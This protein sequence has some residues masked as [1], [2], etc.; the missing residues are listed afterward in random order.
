MSYFRSYFEKN[1]TLIKNSQTNTAKNPTTEIFYG[2]GF[3][4][5]IFKVDL[6]D[7][8]TKVDSGEL[9]I[10]SN[11][12]H[13]L[14]MT[15][16]IFGDEGLRG[17]NRTT[18]R[19]RTSSFD[20]IVFK[21]TQYWD[22]G[23]GF[24]YIDESYDFVSGNKTYDERPSNWFYRTSMNTWT[25]NGV[26]DTN[27]IIVNT[28]HFDNGNENLEVDITDYVNGIIQSGYT[29]QGLGIAFSIVYQDLQTPTD[30]SVAFFT[31]YTQT[32]FEPFVESYFED[33]VVDNRSDFSTQIDQNL[34]L[35]VTE[36]G[37]YVN[38]DQLPIVDVLDNKNILIN[39]L[40]DLQTQL[41]KKGIYKVTF[42]LNDTTCA[43]GK[44]F[45]IDKWKNIKIHGITLDDINQKFIPK[46]LT[47]SIKIGLNS[48]DNEKYAVQFYGVKMSEK[49]K[50][51]DIRKIS[52]NEFIALK[53][54]CGLIFAGFPCQ[55][56]SNAGKK[57]L[58]DPRNELVYE[59]ND[60]CLRVNT[61]VQNYPFHYHIKKFSN[62]IEKTYG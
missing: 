55:G 57:N 28:Q 49:I 27:P 46:P 30:Q 4:K 33:R 40:S 14:H 58:N 15:N 1:N 48:N 21:I 22:E 2:S 13:V 19:D 31:K 32:F 53:G 47:N 37:E 44:R 3:S 34:Y 39:G 60:D 54:K 20:L 35:Y 61:F 62:I 51:G 9:V 25:T 6:K 29:N 52:D 18:G 26:Y 7:L 23:I 38:L 24:D 17:L 41:V 8:K 43:D 56:F 42:N 10:D 5:F 16:T 45:F 11:T 50:R 59:L 12:K 36:N